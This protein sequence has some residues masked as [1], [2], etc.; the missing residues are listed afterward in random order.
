MTT[1]SPIQ[2]LADRVEA[3]RTALQSINLALTPYMP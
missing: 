2:E 1:V 3:A